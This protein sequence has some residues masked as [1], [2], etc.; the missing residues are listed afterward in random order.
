ML[1]PQSFTEFTR[2]HTDTLAALLCGLLLFLGWFALHLGWLGLAFLLLPAAYVIGGYE[3]AREGLTTLFKEKELDVDLLMIVAAIGAASLGLWRR[4]Y[5]LIIDGAILILIFAISGALEGYAMARTE[6][7]IRSLMSLT[8]DTARVLLQGREEK[9]PI[10]QLKVGDEIV[11]KPGELIPTDGIILSGYSTLNQAAITG[12]SLPVEKTVGAE[13]FAGTL[14]GYGALQIKV[15]K[16]AQS[17][18]IQRVIRLVEQAQT[19]A[20]PSQEFID[21]FEKGYAKVIVVA[22]ILLA[23][24]PPFLWG[25]DW[26]TTIYR[27]LTF[28]VVASPCALMAAIMPTLLSGIA[29]GARQGILF[30]NGA[31]LEKIGKVRAIAF[32][33]TGTLTTGQVQVFQVI[34]ISEYTQED[35]LKAAASVESYSEHPIGKAIVQAAGN[36]DLVGAIQVQAIPGQGIVGIAQ[37][38]QVIVGNAVFVQ[39]YVTNLP[40]ELRK[41]AQSLEQEGKTVVWV[42]QEGKGAGEQGGRGAEVMGV[43]AI[44][45]EVRLQA[46]ATISRLKQLGI[47]Q[48]V[49]LTGDNE[50]TAQSVAKAVGID[51]VYAQLLPEDKLD[52][53]RLLQQKYQ[54]VAMVGDGIN[55]APALAQASVGIAMG[56]SGSDVALETADI[57]LMADKLEKIAV[58]MHLGRRSQSIV[59]QNIFVALSFIVLLLV[60][61][62]LGSINLP[63]GVIGHEG[64]TVLVTLSGLRLLK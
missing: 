14:N 20:P 39:H 36:L 7:S 51:R 6:R 56:I 23:T 40:E 43:I 49:M 35:V 62:F 17:S 57:V 30:K 24:L 29:N 54:T 61:N 13:V 19:E 59:K 41:M 60:G 27:A 64:S 4:E 12:E 47:E 9:I 28:L 55:D 8:P 21:R 25:W 5:H 45:D 15:H 22:G 18:L 63:I 48:I 37:E 52:V 38:Q 16:P 11:V 42:A 1:Y 34:A 2:E 58:A 31:Q 10:S 32:D 50:E 46:A 53:I 33:K 3:S 44:A 26:E